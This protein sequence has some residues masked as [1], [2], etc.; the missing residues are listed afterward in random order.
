MDAEAAALPELSLEIAGALED[1][2]DLAVP[3]PK[4]K[5][6][7]EAGGIVC[8]MDGVVLVTGRTITEETLKSASRFSSAAL[9]NLGNVRP[10]IPLNVDPPSHIKYRKIL[11]PL[12]APKRMELWEDEI[13]ARVNVFIDSFVDR[14]YCHFTDEF[15]TP[16]P[17]SVFL[18][19][20]GLPEEELSTFLRFKNGMLRPPSDG[21][22]P[23]E[24]A[25]MQQANGA[26]VYAYFN[27][28]LDER[29]KQP[30]NDILT[31]F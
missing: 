3:Q 5:A 26:E 11:D 13:T 20:M 22:T 14:G 25:Q 10:L 8:P 23:E 9:V 31:Q 2:F 17:S 19:L 30:R 15:A 21:T 6:M 29:T 7:I 12:F 28:I 27:A 1:L 16:F 4:Y 18:A 24:L